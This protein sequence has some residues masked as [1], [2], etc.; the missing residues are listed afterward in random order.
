MVGRLE[1]SVD[2][3]GML[4]SYRRAPPLGAINL[5]KFGPSRVTRAKVDF[6]D[7]ARHA[8]PKSILKI[9]LS[10]RHGRRRENG[11]PGPGAGQGEGQGDRRRAFRPA[12]AIT[13]N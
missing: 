5:D 12:R 10:D 2:I 6:E 8:E 1:P 13:M 9:A 11:R 7:L 4:L 3:T